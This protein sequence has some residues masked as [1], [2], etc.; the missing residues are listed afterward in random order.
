[1]NILKYPHK[2]IGH[3]VRFELKI[4]SQRCLYTLLETV[5][6]IIMLGYQRFQLCVALFLSLSFFFLGFN[7]K[8][9]PATFCLYTNIRFSSLFCQLCSS[10]A[11]FS[12]IL[13]R[14][15]CGNRQRIEA[16]TL[17]FVF[18]LEEKKCHFRT[19]LYPIE[20]QSSSDVTVL[21]LC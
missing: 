15:L 9:L 20:Y 10:D 21:F 11:V 12:M 18:E 4:Q 2:Y 7:F 17:N 19:D 6:G 5:F 14:L 3:S 16:T 13:W 1:M 8:W